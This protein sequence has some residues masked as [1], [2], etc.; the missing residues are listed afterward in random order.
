MDGKKVSYDAIL[1]CG[2][3]VRSVWLSPLPVNGLTYIKTTVRSLELVKG[4]GGELLAN[5][6]GFVRVVHL[7]TC[8]SK[9]KDR[10]VNRNNSVTVKGP[11]KQ[12]VGGTPSGLI[13][14]SEQ[15]LAD[16]IEARRG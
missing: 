9:K 4:P 10:W 7:P 15:E 12:L 2:C 8:R 14:A 1:S 6:K 5:E 13:F 11:Y 16:H 3:P